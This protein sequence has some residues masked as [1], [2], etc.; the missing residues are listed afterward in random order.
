MDLSE[1][2]PKKWWSALISDVFKN[3]LVIGIL[4]LA[5]LAVFITSW[6]GRYDAGYRAGAGEGAV[7]KPLHEQ[8]QVKITTLEKQ[9]EK[10]GAEIRKLQ[11]RVGQLEAKGGFF[12]PNVTQ[13]QAEETLN[14]V[15]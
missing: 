10:D 12:K 11:K 2:K 8:A 7:Y 3:R 9:H 14:Q 15:E 6:N 4:A 5:F 1:Q 13:A